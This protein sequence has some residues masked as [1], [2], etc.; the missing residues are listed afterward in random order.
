[1]NE[2]NS[3][4]L[5]ALQNQLA[6][7]QCGQPSAELAATLIA[8]RLLGNSLTCRAAQSKSLKGHEAH[9]LIKLQSIPT[10]LSGQ[11]SGGLAPPGENRAARASLSKT[12]ATSSSC[13]PQSAPISLRKVSGQPE[14]GDT[15]ERTSRS[16]PSLLVGK[17]QSGSPV[18]AALGR[19]PVKMVAWHFAD[20]PA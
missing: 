11:C 17:A 8:S 7:S 12:S 13:R 1:M 19:P 14:A 9:D 3:S 5:V 15:L 4:A 2:C 6:Q 20:R 16:G 10:L 18:T